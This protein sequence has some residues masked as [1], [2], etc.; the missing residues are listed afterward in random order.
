M[1]VIKRRYWV[2]VL[3][4]V[5]AL[6]G[7][8]GTMAFG[9]ASAAVPPGQIDDGAGLLPQASITLDQAIIAA[10][11]AASGAL[12]EVDLE[13]YQGKLAFNV[14][15]GDKDVKVDASNGAILGWVLGD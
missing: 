1:G 4:A 8:A 6:G 13:M 12:G 14:D 7:T 3:A 11:G 5:I 2:L 15:V 10:Q 9:G